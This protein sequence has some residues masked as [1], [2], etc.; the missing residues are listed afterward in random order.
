MSRVHQT[1]AKSGLT[2]GGNLYVDHRGRAATARKGS[3]REELV[4]GRPD[5][6]FTRR[7]PTA[8]PLK[9]TRSSRSCR[10][11]IRSGRRRICRRVARPGG[12]ATGSTMPRLR[13]GKRPGFSKRSRRDG[14][15]RTSVRSEG[16]AWRGNL[17]HQPINTAA[18]ASAVVSVAMTVHGSDDVARAVDDLPTHRIV[19]RWCCRRDDNLH[20]AQIISLV[21]RYRLRRSTHLVTLPQG[22]LMSYGVDVTELF[23][24]AANYVDRIRKG[25]KP[26]DLPVQLPEKFELCSI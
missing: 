4:D 10:G 8:A 5:I 24:L 9:N 2:E 3:L 7:R 19:V 11:G 26:A 1:D 21:G 18:A 25:V 14:A 23:R 17:L 20:R 15:R 16:G 22:G 13:H 6:L 12:D